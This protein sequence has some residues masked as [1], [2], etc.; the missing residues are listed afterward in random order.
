MI[1]AADPLKERVRV[2]C[3]GLRSAVVSRIV[4]GANGEVLSNELLTINN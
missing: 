2:V 1:V 3:M 4:R